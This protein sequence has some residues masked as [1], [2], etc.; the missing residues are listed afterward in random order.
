M[1]R[2]VALTEEQIRFI[3]QLIEDYVVYNP[4]EQAPAR[5]SYGRRILSALVR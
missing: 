4:V 1:K 2:T 3:R 5:R